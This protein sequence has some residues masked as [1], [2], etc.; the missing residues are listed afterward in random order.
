M[1]R[2]RRDSALQLEDRVCN[3]DGGPGS[4]KDAPRAAAVRLLQSTVVGDVC[5]G[6]TGLRP[7][8][9]MNMIRRRTV[10]RSHY[11]AWG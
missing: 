11:Y 4:P 8:G 7:E 6:K 2:A 5:L 1:W 9:A 10:F 3:D